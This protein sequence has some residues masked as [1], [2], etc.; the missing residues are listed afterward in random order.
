MKE[1]IVKGADITDIIYINFEDE[2]ILPMK[3]EDLQNVLDAYF[4][5]GGYPEITLIQ[6]KGV[7]ARIFQDY[8]NTIFYRDLV[9]R[10]KIKRSELLRQCEYFP[11]LYADS[12]RVCN[13]SI[14]ESLGLDDHSERRLP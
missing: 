13:D 9:D 5:S 2:R 3:A 6:E 7:R 1:V 4:F 12:K 10:Y 8:F 14:F 11:L